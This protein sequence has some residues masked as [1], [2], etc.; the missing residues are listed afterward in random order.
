MMVTLA[1]PRKI[2]FQNDMV[3]TLLLLC[4]TKTYFSGLVDSMEKH[5]PDVLML[6]KHDR[7][8]SRSTGYHLRE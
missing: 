3:I 7:T 8:T 5:V 2:R 6:Y 4:S 1:K